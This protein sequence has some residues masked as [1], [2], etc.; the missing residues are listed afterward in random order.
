MDVIQLEL[1]WVGWPNGLKLASTCVQSSA[2]LISTKVSA[3][4]RKSTQM[5]KA[6]P[7]RYVSRPRFSTCV[8]VWPG[9]YTLREPACFYLQQFLHECR[10]VIA[11]SLPRYMIGLK[12]R[13]N[14]SS[15]QKRNQNQSW[16]IRMCFS[17]LGV[18]YMNFEFWLVYLIVSVLCD[19]PVI[20][21]FGCSFTSPK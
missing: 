20:T 6:C 5:Y 10:K 15:N 3:S 17:A 11:F 16:L 14:F 8:S 12:T 7:N 19:W 2:K 21:N 18:S 13:T 9:L 1:T 4:H